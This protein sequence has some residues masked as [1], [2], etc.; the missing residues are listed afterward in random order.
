MKQGRNKKDYFPL[1]TSLDDKIH[2]NFAWYHIFSKDNRDFLRFNVLNHICL[3]LFYNEKITIPDGLYL[4][5]QREYSKLRN[6]EPLVNGRKGIICIDGCFTWQDWGKLK[7]KVL[8][9]IEPIAAKIELHILNNISK[10]EL[11][12][13]LKDS[14]KIWGGEIFADEDEL[15][16]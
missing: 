15:E 1:L 7:K 11:S 6:I 5:Y 14:P 3:L 8:E 12:E 9:T 16:E 4:V 13:M 10:L 2:F